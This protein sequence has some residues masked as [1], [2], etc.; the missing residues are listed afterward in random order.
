MTYISVGSVQYPPLDTQNF[1]I[2]A[3]AYNNVK[4]YKDWGAPLGDDDDVFTLDHLEDFQ[5]TDFSFLVVMRPA[6]LA[7]DSDPTRPEP[8]PHS[9]YKLD[10]QSLHDVIPQVCLYSMLQLTCL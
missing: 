10:Q 1:M 9:Q 8:Q 7:I 4:I 2:Q 3:E 6:P 5:S